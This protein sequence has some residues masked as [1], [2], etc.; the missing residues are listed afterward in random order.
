MKTSTVKKLIKKK[1]KILQPSQQ[2]GFVETMKEPGQRIDKKGETE[3]KKSLPK[4]NK[5]PKGKENNGNETSKQ[6]EFPSLKHLT[7]VNR[8]HNSLLK[9]R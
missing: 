6:E 8:S 2:R 5:G 1:R 9:G 7:H 3:P 4:L